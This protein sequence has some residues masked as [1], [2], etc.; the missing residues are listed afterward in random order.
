MKRSAS[1]SPLLFDLPLAPDFSQEQQLMK[2]GLKH[3]A[4]I[5]EAGRGPLAGPVVAAAVVLDQNDLP[6]GLDDSKRLTAARREALYEI[7]LTKAITVSVASLSARSID[8]SDIRKAALEAMRRAVI[9]LTL[10]PCHALVDG[11]DVPPGLPC[12]GSALVKGDQRSVSIAAAS[13]VAKVTRDRM[14][15]RA[16]AAHPPYGLE[17]HAGYA[18]QKHRAAI[19]S[20]GPVPGLHRYTFAPIKGRFDC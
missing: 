2:R 6:E 15:I 10:K 12:P 20:E 16:G 19:E 1:D 13:I 9:G 8:A 11:R 17:I 3:I 4:G 14:M 7:I 5:D 18:T